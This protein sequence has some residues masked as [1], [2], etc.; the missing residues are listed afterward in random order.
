[1]KKQKKADPRDSCYYIVS[2]VD[3]ELKFTFYKCYL[4]LFR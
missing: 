1:M 2:P 4:K 3:T